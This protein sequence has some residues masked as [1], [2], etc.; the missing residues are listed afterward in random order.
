V[1]EKAQGAAVAADDGMSL[2][3]YVIEAANYDASHQ[4]DEAVNSLA[5]G[6]KAGDVESMTRLGKRL[7]A[8]DSAPYLPRDG[9]RFLVDAAKAGGAEAPAILAVLSAAGA[10][11]KQSWNE[12]LS[13]FVLAAERG[14]Q[15][16]RDQL[17]VLA[18]DRQLAAAAPEL[19]RTSTNVWKR[20]G[21][22]VAAGP[23]HVAPERNELST[24][25]AVVNFAGLLAP[26]VCDWLIQQA[27]PRLE[28]TSTHSVAKFPLID[29][30]F[31]HLLLQARMAVSCGVPI[32]NMEAPTVLLYRPGQELAN[33][34]ASVDL[35]F[36]V[37]LNDDYEGGE[38]DFPELGVRHRGTQGDG[39]YFVRTR[40][41][42]LPPV[43]GDKWIA[44]Q[45]VRRSS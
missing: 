25:P 36:L 24:D 7:L 45:T 10:H 26:A 43:Q 34:D 30:S 6:V 41:T 28:P 12:G 19:A 35:T 40:H 3:D 1:S 33:Q 4:H 2:S 31:V 29:L 17:C 14:W 11:V 21:Q 13:A 37:C 20:L 8:G 39:L 18:V 22:S 32:Q 44:S 27:K 5:R 15:P 16:A 42:G 23:W 9:A 38:T